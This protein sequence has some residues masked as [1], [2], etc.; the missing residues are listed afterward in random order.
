MV[1]ERGIPDISQRR[2]RHIVRRP[3]DCRRD[4]APTY[5]S[6]APDVD[7]SPRRPCDCLA[8]PT[9]LSRDRRSDGAPVCRND[10]APAFPTCRCD[11]ADISQQRP[12]DRGSD[13]SGMYLRSSQRHVGNVRIYDLTCRSDVALPDMSRPRQCCTNDD[14][15]DISQGI[16]EAMLNFSNIEFSGLPIAGL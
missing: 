9:R 4:V 11:V 8:T 7:I 16:F 13:M 3:C 1:A 14:F 5:R 6:D 2:P 15:L 12:C 10:V